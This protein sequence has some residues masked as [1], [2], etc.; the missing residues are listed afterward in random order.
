MSSLASALPEALAGALLVAGFACWERKQMVWAALAFAG[1]LLVRETAI[2]LV[3]ALF[4]ATLRQDARRTALVLAASVVPIAAWR[5]FVAARLFPDWGWRAIAASPGDLGVP[6]AGLIRLASTGTFAFPLLLAAGLALALW[7]VRER[8]GPLA[9]AA[10][11]YGVVAVSLGYDKIWSH[12][13]SG[14]RGTFELFVC[15]LLLLFERG[16][17]TGVMRGGLVALFVGLLAYT[18]VAA[19]DAATS[20]AALLLIR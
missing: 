1:A 8:V 15:L 19:P 13:P 7:A 20:R 9:I 18:F 6:F 11:V 14:E 16:G 2:V 17:R 4:V 3:G 10:A 5:L 12:L